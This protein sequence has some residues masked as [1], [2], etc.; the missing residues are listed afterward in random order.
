MN[1]LDALIAQAPTAEDPY[2]VGLAIMSA[3]VEPML[4]SD[5]ASRQYVLWG[6]LTDRLELKPEEGADALTAM[7]QAA[8]EWQAVKD[9]STARDEYFDRWLYDVLG[10]ERPA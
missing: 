9:D 10:L 5:I 6:G 7:R 4:T 1:E 8:T 2:E 3:A